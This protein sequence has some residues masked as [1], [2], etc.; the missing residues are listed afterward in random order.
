MSL[1]ATSYA[2]DNDDAAAVDRHNH[3][4]A[5]LDGVTFDRLSS[6]GDLTGRR[7]LEVGAGGGSVARW[8]AA[9]VGPTGRVLATD[10]KP[11]HLTADGGYEVLAHDLLAEPVPQGPWD[12]IHARLVLIHLDDRRGVLRRLAAAL[13]PGG[14]LVVEDWDTSYDR[15]V[16]DAP[17]RESADLWEQYQLTLRR[18]LVAGGNEETWGGQLHGLFTAAGLVDV[19]TEISSRAWPGG[20]PG[21]LLTLANVAQMRDGFLA[22]GWDDER[23]ER[24]ERLAHDPRMVVRAQF[25]FSTIGRRPADAAA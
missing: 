17:D 18:L 2:F 4:P 14:A 22:E 1:S 25:M 16:L 3:L 13:A 21:A 11:R 5:I 7:C 19:Q 20:S 8:L 23:L 15:W 6:L 9:R 24:L 12:L 10:L